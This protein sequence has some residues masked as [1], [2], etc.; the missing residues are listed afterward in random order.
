MPEPFADTLAR[1]A[2]G[3]TALVKRLRDIATRVEELP[4]DSVAEVLGVLEAAVAVCEQR[5][6]VGLERAPTYDS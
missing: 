2:T 5:A 3:Q 4:L 6:A 1:I